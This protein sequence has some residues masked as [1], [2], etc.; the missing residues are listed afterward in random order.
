[1]KQF[2]NLW[3]GFF[4]LPL[5]LAGQTFNDIHVGNLLIIGGGT[6]H[7]LVNDTLYTLSS[8]QSSPKALNFRS[9][10]RTGQLI[11]S[12]FLTWAD[13]G[14]S[15]LAYGPYNFTSNSK[16]NAHYAGIEVYQRNMQIDLKLIAF[17]KTLDTLKSRYWTVPGF[18]RNRTYD[19]IATDSTITVLG[20]CNNFPGKSHL[21]LAQF[22][23]AFNLLWYRTI[24]DFRGGVANSVSG[25]HPYRFQ[26]ASDGYFIVGRCYYPNIMVEGFVVKTDL[27]GHKIWDKRYRY[28]N[29][30]TYLTE[31]ILLEDS[32]L[33]AGSFGV[34]SSGNQDLSQ[35]MVLTMDSSGSVL[36]EKVFPEQRYI[37]PITSMIKTKDS[38][39]VLSSFH[40]HTNIFAV[41]GI[42]TKISSD[43][44]TLWR[45]TYHYGH[46]RQDMSFLYRVSEWSDGGLIST[47]TYYPRCQHFWP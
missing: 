41:Y 37:Y 25:Y 1:M 9:F 28:Q 20:S 33:I 14:I 7:S 47:G 24:E 5:G 21:Y 12:T 46:I 32:L 31:I 10:D 35:M 36:H 39:F 15:F 16:K 4:V 19:L 40:Y 17:N 43:M 22:D 42:L 34:T 23:T 45:R 6:S 27:E 8:D 26:Q 3:F 30:N 29:K 2:V 38:S 11:D 44:N 13:T 18:L